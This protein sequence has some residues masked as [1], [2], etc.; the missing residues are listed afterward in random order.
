MIIDSNYSLTRLFVSKD[1]TITIDKLKKF[2]LKVRS[3]KDLF[4][5]SDW[6]IFYHTA[7]ESVEKL[8]KYFPFGKIETQFDFLKLLMLDFGQFDKYKDVYTIFKNQLQIILP[9]IKIDIQNKEISVNGITITNEIWEY[10]LYI[11]KLSNGEKVEL[12]PTFASEEAKKLYL[13]QKANEEKIRQIRSQ[14]QKDG[15]G[16]IK[17]LLSIT[18][19]FPSMTMD[20]LWEQT[21]AQI[22]WLRKYAAGAVSYEVSAKAFAAGN[23]KK[24]KKLDFFIK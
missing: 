11:L 14:M 20:Y 16:L 13:A 6:N 19:A 18:Y 3:A 2:T 1:I 24:G 15:D 23:V 7:I 9:E 5:D 8:Q 4:Q 22:L 17:S 21:M 10:I 12:P